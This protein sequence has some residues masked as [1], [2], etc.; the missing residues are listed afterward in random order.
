MSQLPEFLVTPHNHFDPTW[1][2]CFDR[3]AD[4]KGVRLRSY[5]E[6]EDMALR[7]CKK[8]FPGIGG[9]IFWMGHDAFPCNANTSLIDFHGQ[10]KP[11]ALAASGIWKTS[12]EMLRN[13]TE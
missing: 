8:R 3:S 10:P 4:Y 6:I 9:I 1:R 2:R 7:S 12:P 13:T 5:A 11:A